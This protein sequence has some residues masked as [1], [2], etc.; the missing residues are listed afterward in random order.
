MLTDFGGYISYL[1]Y[2]DI[3]ESYLKLHMLTERRIGIDN[4]VIQV[5]LLG[6]LNTLSP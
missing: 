1:N 6:R 5:W 3:Y 4:R 2:T